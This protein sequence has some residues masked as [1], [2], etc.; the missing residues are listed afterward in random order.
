MYECG[1]RNG[2]LLEFWP[3]PIIQLGRLINSTLGKT[4]YDFPIF[5]R[6]ADWRSYHD[7]LLM[8]PTDE[9]RLWLFEVDAVWRLLEEGRPDDAINELLA[10]LHDEDSEL[11]LSLEKQ[12]SEIKSNIPFARVNP[13]I[14]SVRK[15]K[16]PDL[17]SAIDK[18][19]EALKDARR[20]CLASIQS[21][22]PIRLLW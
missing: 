15:S 3:G 18:V 20:L 17:Q 11:R 16:R 6:V 8:L 19:V 9:A 12:L 1:H 5:A 13:F 4:G 10:T 14:E 21:G 2:C 22:N 7:E